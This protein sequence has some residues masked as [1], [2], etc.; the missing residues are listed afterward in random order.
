MKKV[1]QTPETTTVLLLGTNAIM[2]GS[3]TT[4]PL[5]LYEGTAGPGIMD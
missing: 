1:Y 2:I 3:I 5:D 4:G